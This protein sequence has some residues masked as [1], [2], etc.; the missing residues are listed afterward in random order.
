MPDH[1]DFNDFETW[2]YNAHWLKFSSID[3][4]L[5]D[6]H[7]YILPSGRIEMVTCKNGKV[8]EITHSN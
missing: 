5:A 2:A 8:M 1:V 3:G 7:K 4:T 6:Y